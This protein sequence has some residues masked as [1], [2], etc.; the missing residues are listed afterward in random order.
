MTL[1]KN[2]LYKL[3]IIE[4]SEKLDHYQSIGDNKTVSLIWEYLKYYYPA[5]IEENPPK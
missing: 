4:L 3:N 2:D 5:N 1:I